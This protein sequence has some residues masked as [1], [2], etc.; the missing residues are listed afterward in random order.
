[1]PLR[2]ERRFVL[3]DVA[4]VLKGRFSLTDRAGKDETAT[5]H[6]AMFNRRLRQQRFFRTP[7]L[8]MADCV[9]TVRP[10]GEAGFPVAD[11]RLQGVRDLGWML[12]DRSPER[13]GY[14]FFRPQTVDGMIDTSLDDDPVTAC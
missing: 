3:R 10:I 5:Q 2:S 6:I 14:I 4:Y 11:E 13:S 7:Y 9:A 8:G 1:M 12:H